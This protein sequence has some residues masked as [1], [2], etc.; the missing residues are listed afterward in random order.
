MK[1]NE[2]KVK[3]DL[4]EI[5]RLLKEAYNKNSMASKDIITINVIGKIDTLLTIIDWEE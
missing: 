1:L 3:D 5:K 4:S 2:Q